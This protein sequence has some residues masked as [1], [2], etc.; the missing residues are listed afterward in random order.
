MARTDPERAEVQEFFGLHFADIAD[1]AENAVPVVAHDDLYRPVIPFIRES[2]GR[3]VAA[4]L[5]NRPM[6][7]AGSVMMGGKLPNGVDYGPVL[8]DVYQLDLITVAA[9]H[10]GQGLGTRLLSAVDAELSARGTRVIFGCVTDEHDVQHLQSFYT[11]AG[12]KVLDQGQPLPQFRGR[13]WVG[14]LDAA[15]AFYFYRQLPRA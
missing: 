2:E 8:D 13:T 7:A 9:D 11:A 5:A 3:V 15:P 10:R 14:A 6:I 12:F 4:A 1:I